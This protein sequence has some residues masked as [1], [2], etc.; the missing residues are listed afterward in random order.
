MLVLVPASAHCIRMSLPTTALALNNEICW[1]RS[2]AE[3]FRS[4][5]HMVLFAI[6]DTVIFDNLGRLAIEHDADSILLLSGSILTS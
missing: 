1:N 6:V 2:I 3:A 4:P 5:L